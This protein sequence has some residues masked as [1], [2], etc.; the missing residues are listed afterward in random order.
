MNVK[1]FF[2][3]AEKNRILGAIKEAELE[4][5]GEIR[6][7]LETRCKGDALDRAVELFE[8]LK[9]HETRLHNGTLIYLAVEDRKFAIFGDEGINSVVPENFWQDVKEEMRRYF[10]EKKFADGLVTGIA[11]VGHKLKAFFPYQD[12]DVNEL[13]D[14]IS[15]GD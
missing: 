3:D 4:T 12:D 13:P 14:D 11:Q 6:L 2:S 10:T 15:T 8:K 9:M 7:H 5:S 1:K